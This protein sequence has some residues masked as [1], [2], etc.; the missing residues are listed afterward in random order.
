MKTFLI[1][2]ILCQQL[3]MRALQRTVSGAWRQWL[4]G[5]TLLV[6]ASAS[7]AAL[8][9]R[10]GGL[11]YDTV[12]DV[13][14]LQDA[15]YARTQGIGGRLGR[16]PWADAMA[17]V[18]QLV[19]HDVVRNLT[20]SNWRLPSIAPLN[21]VRFRF[22]TSTSGNTDDGYNISAPGTRYAGSTA[23]ELAYMYYNNLGNIGRC[24]ITGWNDCL[25]TPVDLNPGPFINLF[26]AVYWFNSKES[27]PFAPV[28]AWGLDMGFQYGAQGGYNGNRGGAAWAVMDGDVALVDGGG[29][30][31]GLIPEPGTI[32]L[33]GLGMLGL[34][35]VARRSKS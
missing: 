2:R 16:M 5:A 10:G 19:Y 15:N 12:L 11:I 9:D 28:D 34:R 32:A 20:L 17:W 29:G 21:G 13:T 35:F 8:L 23:S 24:P 22:A 26:G 6:A 25:T 14:W 33:L 27:L 3:R 7:N 30:P 1:L 31:P 18:D 4:S